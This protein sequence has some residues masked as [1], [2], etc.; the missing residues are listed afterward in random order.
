MKNSERILMYL[1]NSFINDDGREIERWTDWQA[2]I[3]PMETDKNKFLPTKYYV[4]AIIPTAAGILRSRLQVKVETPQ[5]A[6]DIHKETIEAF[7]KKMQE[8]MAE[9]EA[10]NRIIHAG[11][12]PQ[13]KLIV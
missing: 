10:K 7:E 5:Q 9:R 6:L 1:I 2:S 3:N 12:I 13:N 11:N 4:I 8:M